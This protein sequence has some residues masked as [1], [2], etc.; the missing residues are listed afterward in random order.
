MEGCGTDK[1][2][3]GT[4]SGSS[5]PLRSSQARMWGMRWVRLW[6]ER[7]LG[8]G[9][10]CS[11]EWV[12]ERVPLSVRG[13]SVEENSTGHPASTSQFTVFISRFI[14]TPSLISP[15]DVCVCSGHA[16]FST[17]YIHIYAHSFATASP[18]LPCCSSKHPSKNAPNPS[19]AS[20]S[21]TLATYWSGR[22]TTTAPTAGPT[23]YAWYA[24]PWPWL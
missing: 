14:S 16:G 21:R 13:F 4:A 24:C 9:R 23:P 2:C 6:V 3:L 8:A 15:S 1:C 19:T 12:S 7:Y 17:T 20:K 18:P 5:G 11:S 10:S 22:T